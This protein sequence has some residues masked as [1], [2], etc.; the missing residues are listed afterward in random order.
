MDPV[1]FTIAG[2]EVRWYG[3]LIS[4]GILL[5]LHLALQ[6]IRRLGEDED[7]FI[8]LFM[9]VIPAAIVGARLYYV[10]F[11]GMLT[12]YLRHPLELINT[13]HGGLAIHGG[14]IGGFLVGWLFTRRHKINFRK[15]ADVVAP[16]VILGQAIGRWGNY[17]NQEAYGRETNL[18]WAMYIDGAYRHP[19]FLYEFLWNLL[20][21]AWLLRR[22]RHKKFEG[23]LVLWYFLLYSVGRFFIE[24]LRTDSLMLGP[25]RVAQLLSLSLILLCSYL[26]WRGNRKAKSV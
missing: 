20:V 6:E 22:R 13:R 17:F 1:A 24:G 5:G 11:S 3:I 10:A 21:F 8:S 25:F 19:T 23:E 9:Y 16:S 15:W 4:F 2:I 12:W 7:K 26:L 18:P 14:L